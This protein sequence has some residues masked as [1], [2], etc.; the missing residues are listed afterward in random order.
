MSSDAVKTSTLYVSPEFFGVYGLKQVAGRLYDPIRDKVEDEDK[1]VVNEA[2]ARRFGF[3]SSQDAVG[4]YV[5]NP[6]GSGTAMQVIGVAPDIR[7]RSAREAMQPTV[8]FL[9][10][11]T[12]VF[13]VRTSGSQEAVKRAIEELWPRY[14]PNDVLDIQRAAGMFALNYADD[15]RLAKLLGA[16]SVI[17]TAIAAFGIYVLAAYSVQRKAREIVLRKLYG[18]GNGAVGRLVGKEFAALLGV[19]ALIGLPAAWLAIERYLAGFTER[20]PIG[21]WTIAAAL[22]V[23]CLVA[24]G[25]T[26]RHALAAMRIR[27]AL[28]LRE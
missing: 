27:P 12:P 18:A 22:L 5:R 1:I 17:A 14:F 24:L 19:G 10:S 11:R 3:A 28:A 23:A 9:E 2:G 15:L 26:A 21:V 16:S 4:K 20:A 13:T 8:Y 7:H 6:D 25:S